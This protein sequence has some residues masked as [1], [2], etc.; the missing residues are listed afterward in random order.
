LG[1]FT[2]VTLRFYALKAL[3]SSV[4]KRTK[5]FKLEASTTERGVQRKVVRVR[6]NV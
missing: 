5:V 2:S 3:L 6:P 4:A 1:T